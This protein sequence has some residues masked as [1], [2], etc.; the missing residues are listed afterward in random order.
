[1]RKQAALVVALMIA[2]TAVDAAEK[3]I[4]LGGTVGEEVTVDADF[5]G[6]GVVA[7]DRSYKLFGGLSLG[8]HFAVELAYH[9]FGARTCCRPE[10]ADFGF[11]VALDGYSAAF[12]ARYPV[13]RFD[14]FAKLGYLVWEEDGELITIAGPQS[15][16]ADGSDPMA[17]AGTVFRATDHFGLRL[18]WEYFELDGIGPGA[19]DDAVDVFSGGVQ[20]KF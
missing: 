18:E 15:Y 6:L 8:D 9:D 7:E 10:V 17:G 20:Y 19:V 4:Y 11:D 1:M 5:S 13:R 2:S 16:S 3:R 14:L 12:V